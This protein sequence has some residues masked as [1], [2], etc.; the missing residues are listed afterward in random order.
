MLT[1]RDVVLAQ[2]DFRLAA[3]LTVKSQTITAIIGPSGGGKSTLLSAVAGFLTPIAGDVIWNDATIT[4]L[5]PSQRPVSILF[6][7][8]NLFPHLTI[9]DNIGLALRPDLRLAAHD[10]TRIEHV[11]ADV[12][13][14]GMGGRKPSALSGGQ[15]SRAAL[16]RIL[17]A[18]RDVVLLD[19]P[20]AALGPGLKAEMLELVRTKVA[21]SGKT[22]LMVTH[23]PQDALG[24][25]D[26]AILVADGRAYEPVDTKAMFADPPQALR[27]Y[28]GL[29]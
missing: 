19:E 20:F 7:D 17:L 13:L 4:A 16:A 5:L 1:F 6:Q 28:L 11:L 27:D 15:Q 8:N 21:G 23:D 26:Q 25:A 14:K 18:D 10:K 24:I 22:V 2:G 3:D 29:A 9:A 12:G